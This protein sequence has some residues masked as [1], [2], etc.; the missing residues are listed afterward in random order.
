MKSHTMDDTL[1]VEEER[2][3][4][5]SAEDTDDVEKSTVSWSLSRRFASMTREIMETLW[6]C[7]IPTAPLISLFATF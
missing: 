4:A 2:A 5:E 7:P 3:D 1:K 6:P